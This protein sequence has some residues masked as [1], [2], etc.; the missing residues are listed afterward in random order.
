MRGAK[1]IK[2][3][4]AGL[5]I[6]SVIY[7]I[8]FARRQYVIPI[9]MYHSV[10]PNADPENRLVVSPGT[11]ERQMRYLKNHKYNVVSLKEVA[12][13]LTHNVKIPSKTI[14]ITFDDGYRDNFQYAFPV[15]KKYNL[16]ATIFIILNE[17]GRSQQDRLSWEEIIIMRDSGLIT[18][19]SHALGPE[20]LINIKS[21]DE[22]K[23]Q[24]FES[25]RLLE[26]KLK[27]KVDIFSYAGGMHN[28][29]IKNL[30]AEAGYKIA[31]V[32]NP[33]KK[34]PNND[35]LALKRLRIS[36]N[37]KNLFIFWIETS[38]YYNFIREQRHK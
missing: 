22:L 13:L 30:V 10:S 38:G 2:L 26:D 35:V 33:G 14:A 3:V 27:E 12:Y 31:V 34:F 1:K 24:I 37:A 4:I 5:L 25:K 15:L 23:R 19:G 32:T 20:P 7:I 8:L 6:F 29:A 11:F 21:A 17:V 18:F 36:E 28:D 9:I 16:P